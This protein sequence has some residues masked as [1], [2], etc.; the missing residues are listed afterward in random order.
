AHEHTRATQQPAIVLRRKRTGDAHAVQAPGWIAEADA[1]SLE[2]GPGGSCDYELACESRVP[3]RARPP[4]RRQDAVEPLLR[5]VCRI[6]DR[7]DVPSP[8]LRLPGGL[9]RNREND[10]ALLVARSARKLGEPALAPRQQQRSLAQPPPL[11]RPLP[12]PVAATTVAGG[13]GV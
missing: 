7:R 10:R 1:C 3:I 11:Q 8:G 9:D 2:L 12:Q 6:R 5:R 13:G 4:P